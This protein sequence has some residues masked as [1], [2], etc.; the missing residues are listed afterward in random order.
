V[1]VRGA[2]VRRAGFAASVAAGLSLMALSVGGMATLDEQLAAASKP[3]PARERVVLE[4]A[5]DGA[6][7]R[8]CPPER[9]KR[10]ASRSG[11]AT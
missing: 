6:R 4:P 3:S 9:R 7:D 8:D 5:R 1:S 11:D 10:P 2:T